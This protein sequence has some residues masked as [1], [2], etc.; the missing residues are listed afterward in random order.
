MNTKPHLNIGQGLGRYFRVSQ[1][2]LVISVP[3]VEE[4]IAARIQS[5]IL[6]LGEVGMS[7]GLS[8]HPFQ[9]EHAK[10]ILERL[11]KPE[12]DVSM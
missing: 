10:R 4:Q 11:D 3:P 1:P 7:T 8:L 6:A 9:E 12:T 2:R 5:K